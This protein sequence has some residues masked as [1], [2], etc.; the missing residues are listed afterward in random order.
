MKVARIARDYQRAVFLAQAF[1]GVIH[2]DEGLADLM[3]RC[4]DVFA[5][6]IMDEG[7]AP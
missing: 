7:R 2:W 1:N 5:S 6:A 3:S 4:A